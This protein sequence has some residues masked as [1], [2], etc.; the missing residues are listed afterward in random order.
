VNA[1]ARVGALADGD[2][3]LASAETASLAGTRPVS[4]P[5]SVTL[6]GFATRSTSFSIQWSCR[7]P[8]GSS[9]HQS[10]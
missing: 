3:I 5:R 9:S 2:E 7:Q 4:G 6:K 1:A 10:A 8:Q